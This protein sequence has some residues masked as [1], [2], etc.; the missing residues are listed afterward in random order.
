MIIFLIFLWWCIG[1]ASFI[2]WW[3]KDQD[4]TLGIQVLLA[5]AVGFMGP[6]AFLIGFFVH[7]DDREV[8][9]IFKRRNNE[10]KP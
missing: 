4:F 6:L 9:I 3:T 5:A 2:Y 10:T 7:N 8:I 1:V